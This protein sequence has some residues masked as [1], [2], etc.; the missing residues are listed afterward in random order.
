[1]KYLICFSKSYHFTTE[2]KSDKQVKTIHRA[3]LP[4]SLLLGAGSIK[5]SAQMLYHY[6]FRSS[7]MNLSL[8]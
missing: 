1:M 2:S 5:K 7:L 8:G 6:H 4:L 3:T